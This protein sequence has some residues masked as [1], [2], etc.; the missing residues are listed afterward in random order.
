[1][2]EKKMPAGVDVAFAAAIFG[3]S[4]L[5]AKLLLGEVSPVLLGGLLYLGSSAGLSLV[6]LARRQSTLGASE[7]VPLGIQINWAR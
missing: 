3:A 4:T 1:M 2:F 7:A 5:F 6:R